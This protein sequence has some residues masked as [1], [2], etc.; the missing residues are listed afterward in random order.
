[1]NIVRKLPNELQTK[2]FLYL[3]NPEADVMRN[4]RETLRKDGEEYIDF[5]LEFVELAF[6]RYWCVISQA[7]Y[8]YKY[9]HATFWIGMY[10]DRYDVNSSCFRA[11][12]CPRLLLMSIKGMKEM[13]GHYH[14]KYLYKLL[15]QNADL[16][17]NITLFNCFFGIKACEG[18]P[19]CATYHRGT[20]ELFDGED[21]SDFND[22]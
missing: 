22:P 1:M 16:E 3:S 10:Q 2:I 14:N 6:K 11:D 9:Y 18:E 4:F 8:C 7:E 20:C 17:I 5:C 21:W 12:A 13:I 15:K 19:S